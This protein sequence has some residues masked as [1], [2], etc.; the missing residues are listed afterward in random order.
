VMAAY[1]PW[2]TMRV[3]DDDQGWVLLEGLRS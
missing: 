1:A 3:G 2:F